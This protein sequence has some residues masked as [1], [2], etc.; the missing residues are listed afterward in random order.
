MKYQFFTDPVAFC[1]INDYYTEDEVEQ[2]LQNLDNLRNELQTPENTGSA[3]NISG[4]LRKQN[5]GVFIENDESVLIKLN[6]KLFGEVAWDLSKHNWF[7]DYL[8]Q[9]VYD[10]TLVSYYEDGGYYKPH[11]DKSIVTA[12]YYVWKEP[13]SFDGGEL[14]FGE[15]KVPIV[16]NCLL[17]FPSTTEHEVKMVKGSGRWAITQFVSPNQEKPEIHHFPNC[18]EYRDFQHIQEVLAKG[19][20]IFTGKSHP[21]DPVSKFWYMDLMDDKFFTEYLKSYIEH[22]TK[23]KFSTLYKVYA[24]GQTRGQDG[25]FHQDDVRP[26]TWTFLLYTNV[27]EPQQI[28]SWG[29]VT[30]FKTQ[31]GILSQFP[32]TNHGMLFRSEISHRGLGPSIHVPE[33]RKTIAWKLIE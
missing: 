22:I 21:D 5:K 15:F 16:N 20:W 6:R 32:Y 30:Q 24:N 9:D 26:G 31:Y 25:E 4:Q 3:R 8:K 18:V 7:Y 14:Y 1:I 28:E 29:G 10:R 27:I 23:R 19:R 12:I 33:I 17:V 2:I 13:K 11:R